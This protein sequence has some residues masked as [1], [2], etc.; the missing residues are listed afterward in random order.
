MKKSCEN[1]I[2]Y[3]VCVEYAKLSHSFRT[4]HNW[5]TTHSFFVDQDAG[6]LELSLHQA[7]ASICKNYRK[8]D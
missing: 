7:V 1:C 6:I 2:H 8:E 4:L 3:N 5:V